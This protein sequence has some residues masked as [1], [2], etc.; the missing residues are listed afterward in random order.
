MEN[1]YMKLLQ[2]FEITGM[3]SKKSISPFMERHFSKPT[4]SSEEHFAWHKQNRDAELFLIDVRS[5]GHFDFEQYES[6]HIRPG[7]WFDEVNVNARLTIA[8]LAYL[9]DYKANQRITKNSNLQTIAISL[10]VMLTAITLIVTLRNSTSTSQVSTLEIHIRQQTQQLH[11]LQI[12]LSQATNML[13]LQK[14][15][16]KTL[17]K[18]N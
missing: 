11:T 3:S 8:G 15:A 16:T 13:L 1:I 7:R 6:S 4:A 17:P 18:K 9:E 14:E 5:T 12:Q 2:E 10:T